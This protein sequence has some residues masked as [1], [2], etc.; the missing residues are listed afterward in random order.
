MKSS[1]KLR[2]NR[3][4]IRIDGSAALFFQVIINSKKT[5]VPLDLHWPAEKVDEEK[6]MILPRHRGDKL[7]EDYCRAI[8]RKAG[9][10]NEV[11]IWARL[12][13][14]ELSVDSFQR[15]LANQHSRDDFAA[16]WERKVEEN[17]QKGR[18]KKATW[19]AQKSSL[20]TLK[21]YQARVAFSDLS[22]TWLDDYKTWLFR[23]VGSGNT[24]WKKLKDMRTYCNWAKKD[25]YV[26]IYPFKGFKMPTVVSRVDYLNE[27]EFLTLKRHFYSDKLEEGHV[28]TLR[29][30]LFSCYTGLRISDLMAI[31]W[32]EV[33]RGTLKFKPYKKTRDIMEEINVPLHPQ[34][35]RLLITQKGKLLE[36][37]V[38]QSMNRT[39]KVIATLLDL[40]PKISF[41]WARHTFATRFLRH[42]GRLEVLQQLLGHKKIETT[43]IYVHVDEERKR[44]E[45]DLMPE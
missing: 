33:R 24:V 10:I 17:Y 22:T 7:H 38:E 26:F 3:Q 31:T 34:A 30:F 23:Q 15:E 20:V 37:V 43:M 6:E 45:I 35:A 27:E 41:H 13:R 25:Q 39:I 2:I 21:Q 29:A 36:T 18:I 14:I 8:D 32:K 28:K 1:Y 19:S 9:E 4:R 40:N 12:S 5:T 11:F 44:K 16:Y 42:G